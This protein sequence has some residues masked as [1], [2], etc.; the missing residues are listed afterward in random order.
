MW[1][2]PNLDLAEY[3]I[4][5]V[6]RTDKTATNPDGE[7]VS[8]PY[9]FS[10]S[11]NGSQIELVWDIPH[12]KSCDILEGERYIMINGARVDNAWQTPYDLTGQMQQMQ[13]YINAAIN[14]ADSA[15]TAAA[16]AQSL[17][18][19]ISADIETLTAGF[20]YKSREW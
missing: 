19:S 13:T 9:I 1:D 18:E 7:T 10:A 6:A 17:L 2:M 5:P 12:D 15:T 3:D 16:Q 4:H 11:I 8:F 14:A 20:Q